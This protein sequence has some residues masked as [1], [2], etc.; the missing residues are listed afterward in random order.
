MGWVEVDGRD[1]AECDDMKSHLGPFGVFVDVD[2]DAC[3]MISFWC[4]LFFLFCFVSI[5]G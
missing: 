2:V 1:A 4:C 3:V 5:K